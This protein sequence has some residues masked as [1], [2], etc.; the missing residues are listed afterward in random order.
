MNITITNAGLEALVNASAT[1]TAAV[2]IAKIG[3]GSGRYTPSKTQTELQSEFKQL[4]VIEGGATGDSSIHIAVRDESEDS[5]SIYEFGLYLED[6]TL[7]AVCS[8]QD[9]IL[10]KVSTSQAL[11]SVDV[12]FDGV[13]TTSISFEGMTY[14]FSAATTENAGIVE[15]ATGDE[16]AAGTDAQR[17]VTPKTLA[18]LL[19]SETRAGVIKIASSDEAKAGTDSSKSITAAALKAALDARAAGENSAI[20]GTSTTEFLTPKSVLAITAGTGKK[21]LVELATEEEAKTGTDAQRAV[22]PAG[23]KA[24]FEN[25]LK[26]ATEETAGTVRLATSDEAKAGSNQSA[27]VSPA[28]L[29]VAIDERAASVQEISVGTS[30]GKFVTP[31]GLKSVID[32]LNRTIEDLSARLEALEGEG[33]A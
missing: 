21:G 31:A 13:D 28:N 27:A 5:Y 23:M 6:G 18:G 14:S 4:N 2:T 22:T 15:I 16:V 26:S 25:S 19:A 33:N 12:K 3:F 17:V 32:S 20:A 1:G 9:V 7:F 10:Q 24:A 29:K 11:L 8:Q 30:T